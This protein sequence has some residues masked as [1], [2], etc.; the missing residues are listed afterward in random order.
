MAT[1]PSW[2]LLES[3]LRPQLPSQTV[4][5]QASSQEAPPGPRRK[6]WFWERDEDAGKDGQE[7]SKSGGRNAR[8]KARGPPPRQ[9]ATKA[10]LRPRAKF[11]LA[12]LQAR[13]PGDQAISP[14]RF[15]VKHCAPPAPAASGGR[16]GAWSH[17]SF[18]GG[19][20]SK[21]SRSQVCCTAEPALRPCRGPARS[22]RDQGRLGT[23]LRAADPRQVPVTAART[24]CQ[25][26]ACA[27]RFGL[28]MELEC[29]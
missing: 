16:R 26:R 27:G 24:C 2:N 20:R 21:G 9:G 3:Q 10:W 18:S 1:P 5:G 22:H 13:S 6:S 29:L 17:A 15:R 14:Y 8:A 11:C 4:P 19:P 7:R 23:C 28:S 12:P 25:Q